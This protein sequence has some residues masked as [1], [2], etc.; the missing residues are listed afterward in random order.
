MA[1]ALIT[2]DPSAEGSIVQHV[3]AKILADA[4]TDPAYAARVQATQAEQGQT[5]PSK[6]DLYAVV[7]DG[8]VQDD[9]TILF[10]WKAYT[11]NK[12]PQS[13]SQV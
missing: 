8:T 11:A 4:G 13:R 12:R 3:F 1:R 7:D 2:T 5:D 10:Q 9:G 6:L